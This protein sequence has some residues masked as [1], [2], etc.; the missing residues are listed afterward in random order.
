MSD[1]TTFIGLDVG[2]AA[3]E[4]FIAGLDQPRTITNDRSGLAALLR[5]IRK[6]AN[7]HVILEATGGL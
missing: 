1:N 4:V 5:Q 3:I 2:K 6:I 7:V